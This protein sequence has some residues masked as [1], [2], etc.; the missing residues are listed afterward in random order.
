MSNVGR[1]EWAREGLSATVQ[2][3]RAPEVYP[4]KAG[5]AESKGISSKDKWTLAPTSVFVVVVLF[6]L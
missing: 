4:V 5:C 3:L 1:Q 6:W 2:I